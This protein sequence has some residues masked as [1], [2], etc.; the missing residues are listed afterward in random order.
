MEQLKVWIDKHEVIEVERY[1]CVET[2]T[3]VY[4]I[5]ECR[6]TGRLTINKEDGSQGRLCVFPRYSNE[7]DVE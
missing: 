3:G 2:K 5:N 4:R 1:I 6:I 7:I